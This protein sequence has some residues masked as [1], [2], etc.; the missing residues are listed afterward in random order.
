MCWHRGN[1]QVPAPRTIP[2]ELRRE[3]IG[4]IFLLLITIPEATVHHSGTTIVVMPSFND[5]SESPPIMKSTIP[6]M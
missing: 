6:D 3:L 1:V 5:G 4:L 2:S